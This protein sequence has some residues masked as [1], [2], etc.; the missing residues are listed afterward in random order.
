[1]LYPASST[2]AEE[3]S[4]EYQIAS[5]LSLWQCSASESFLKMSRAICATQEVRRPHRHICI[6]SSSRL[7]MQLLQGDE[8]QVCSLLIGKD[9]TLRLLLQGLA[10]TARHSCK[11][12]SNN[13][14]GLPK[15]H[16]KIIQHCLMMHSEAKRLTRSMPSV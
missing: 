11:P 12:V 8:Q 5:H 15:L 4:S 13:F 16:S 7:A 6:K 10:S 3:P 2:A 1:M 14:C 9:D